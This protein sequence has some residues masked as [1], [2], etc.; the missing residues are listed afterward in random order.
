[1]RNRLVPDLPDGLRRKADFSVWS[2]VAGTAYYAG[3]YLMLLR[4]GARAAL[5]DP[6]GTAQRC[7]ELASKFRSHAE[8]RCRSP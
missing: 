6:V 1:M 5:R 7:A 2:Q 4:A 8:A 3:D